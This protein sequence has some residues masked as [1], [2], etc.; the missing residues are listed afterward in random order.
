MRHSIL[1]TR[2]SSA[3]PRPEPLRWLLALLVAILGLAWPNAARAEQGGDDSQPE[4]ANQGAEP[5]EAILEKPEPSQG[6]YLGLGLTTVAATAFD[7]DRGLRRPTYGNGLG[8]RLGQSVTSW[9]DLGIAISGASTRGDEGDAMDYGSLRVQSQ[10]YPLQQWFVR[11]GFG[12]H[13]AVGTDPED[14]E[15][16]RGTYGAVFEFG[17]GV[18]IFL[19]DANESGGW[20]LTPV[21]THEIGSDAEF[22]TYAIAL[23]VEI[24]WWSGLDRDKLDLSIDEAYAETEKPPPAQAKREASNSIFG[25][26][27]GPGQGLTTYYERAFGNVG[28]RLGFGYTGVTEEDSESSEG[29]LIT[30]PLMVSYLGFG[31]DTHIFEVGAGG[32]LAYVDGTMS[33]FG[34]D[35]KG[36]GLGGW[37]AAVVG[38]R[39]QPLDGGFQFRIG[40]SPLVTPD[41]FVPSVYLSFGGTF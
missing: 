8:L 6:H 3:V 36:S 17:T 5:E 32:A 28:A 4:H 21:L 7:E 34:I 13:F 41:G 24:S 30:V 9:L 16:D 12:P 10:V 27:G 11:G 2:P 26:L 20:V 14:P 35:S 22:M 39:R 15:Y 37:G 18:N 40:T 38:Y 1:S 23:G 25:E 29:Y 19:S 31:S 33:K